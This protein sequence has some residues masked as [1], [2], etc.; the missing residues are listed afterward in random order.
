MSSPVEYALHV[1]FSL[2][3]TES[4]CSKNGSVGLS[5]V[6]ANSFATLAYTNDD[7]CA[8]ENSSFALLHVTLAPA[9]SVSVSLTRLPA[10]LVILISGPVRPGATVALPAAVH[11]TVPSAADVVATPL[12]ACTTSGAGLGLRL[13]SGRAA[14]RE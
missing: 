2:T 7:S 5:R 11:V 9:T 10:R 3:L 14:C 6:R 1:S 13:K 4:C 8:S 12:T